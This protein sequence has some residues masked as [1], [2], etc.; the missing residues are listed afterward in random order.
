MSRSDASPTKPSGPGRPKDPAKRAAILEAAKRMFTQHGFDGAS[1]DQIA[2][3][4]GVSK[5]TVYSHFG[6]K[7]GLF[8]A[9]VKSHCEQSL[10]TTLFHARPDMPLR[11]RLLE[12]AEA[13]YA[14]ISSPE[15]VAGH[16]MLCS[17]QLAESPLP[18]LFWEAG[19][20]RVQDD[21]A[22]LLQRRIEAGELAVPDV[23][24]AAG[25]FF[26]L[27]KGEPHAQLVFGCCQPGT[28]DIQ[29][30]LAASVDMFLS[31]YG[32]RVDHRPY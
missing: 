9:A 15:A 26:T 14:M 4:A 22:E 16:R 12:I 31:A 19:P 21:F 10:P 20:M 7:E 23:A 1:M 8:G 17:P 3:E 5:L 25:Q 6:D 29:A 28:A 13:F 2:T 32:V 30:H 18:R 11:E 24:R 27:L